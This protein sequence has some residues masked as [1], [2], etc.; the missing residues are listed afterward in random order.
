M[1]IILFLL[2]EGEKDQKNTDWYHFIRNLPDEVDIPCFWH[3]KE[4]ELFRDPKIRKGLLRQLNTYKKI[5]QDLLALI[6]AYPALFPSKSASYCS[7][8]I[9]RY[10]THLFS[11]A[12]GPVDYLMMVPL[13]EMLNHENVNV[14]FGKKFGEEKPYDQE[15]GEDYR[16]TSSEELSD[17]DQYSDS[18]FEYDPVPQTPSEED[19]SQHLSNPKIQDLFKDLSKLQSQLTQELDFFRIPDTLFYA[20]LLAKVDELA[21]LS[22]NQKNFKN[23][24]PRLTQKYD[25]IKKFAKSEK[26]RL[27]EERLPKSEETEEKA[28]SKP[29]KPALEKLPFLESFARPDSFEHFYIKT[30]RSEYFRKGSQ[31]YLCYG[32]LDNMYMLKKYGMA[33]E[34]NRY[35]KVLVRVNHLR[36]M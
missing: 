28:S 6:Q 24:L 22:R 7:E 17:S 15:Y 36:E 4:W 8:K 20:R 3:E 9:K 30:K 18:D 11:R 16:T 14:S 13:A 21:E 29:K 25:E 10:Y 19:P 31:V 32:R 27:L 12:F 33:L 35:D 23:A 2:S 5:E 1:V 34:D 26:A